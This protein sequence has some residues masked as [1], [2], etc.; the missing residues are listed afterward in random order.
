MY[1]ILPGFF[2]A[3]FLQS[4][5]MKLGGELGYNANSTVCGPFVG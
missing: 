5:E 4:R 1:D 3:I 2:P